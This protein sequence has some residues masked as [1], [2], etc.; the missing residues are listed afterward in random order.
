MNCNTF[1][2]NSLYYLENEM[3]GVINNDMS[4]HLEQCAECSKFY[5]EKLQL[6]KAFAEYYKIPIGTTTTFNAEIIGK[7]N[8]SYYS[9][10]PVRKLSF[11]LKRN[12]F[13]YMLAAFSALFI[14]FALPMIKGSLINLQNGKII[15]SEVNQATENTNTETN[16][17]G[18]NFNVP[19]ENDNTQKM[20]KVNYNLATTVTSE[21]GLNIYSF[22]EKEFA[23]WIDTNKMLLFTPKKGEKAPSTPY[24]V[25]G[26]AVYDTETGEMKEFTDTK[27][28]GFIGISPD[29]KYVLY[30]EP[31]YIP[32]TDSEKWQ[33][34]YNSGELFHY[35]IKLL[36]IKDGSIA[37]FNAKYKNKDA[38]YKWI[39]DEMILAVYP[40]EKQW[41]INNIKGELIKSGNLSSDNY[42]GLTGADIKVLG[43]DITGTIYIKEAEG[44]PTKIIAIDV[45]TNE[46]KT[47][48]SKEIAAWCT[49]QGG[50]ML[51]DGNGTK[52]I[53]IQSLDND[54]NVLKDY[55]IPEMANVE[56]SVISPDKTKIAL[57]GNFGGWE[58]KVMLMDLNTGELKDLVTCGSIENLSWSN[59]GT[60]ISLASRTSW[61]DTPRSYIINS[62]NP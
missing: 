60:F 32:E 24:P 18:P 7:L 41:E 30:Y 29:K 22:E 12:K 47:I 20:A 25:R 2:K 40:Y 21:H 4:E 19:V 34:E 54:G 8:G 37:D 10:S 45:N 43:S 56:E 51:L 15:T 6:R 48:V 61:E 27:V 3:S 14:V 53:V 26:L 17:E 49:F 9:K 31:K 50:I 38:A 39:N 11:H 62:I 52:D 44:A 42:L 59:D 55:R 23:G 13:N 46:A 28:G 57:A 16:M 5:A 33:E 36:N 58:R 1:K 35:V